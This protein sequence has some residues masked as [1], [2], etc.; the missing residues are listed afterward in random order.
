MEEKLA[1]LENVVFQVKLGTYAEKC[2]RISNLASYIAKKVGLKPASTR[3]S[4]LLCKADLVSDMVGEF[5]D[6]QG[7]MGS[8]YARHDGEA[9][10]VCVAIAEHY[11]PTQSGGVLPTSEVGSCVA[12][13]DKIDSLVG[14]FGIKQPPTGSRDP[15]AL[16]RQA[17][18]V[19]RICIEN[20]VNLCLEGVLAESARLYGKGF[21][22]TSVSAYIVERL[23]NY[24]QELGIAG[25]VV[26]AATNS[27]NMSINL[28]E[29]DDVVRTLQSF[30]DG[31]TAGSI[32]AANKRVANLLKKAGPNELIGAF[33]SSLASEEA[34]IRLGRA[35]IGLDL[36]KSKGAGEKL[37]KLA[38]LQGPVD[39][40]FDEVMVMA[41]DHKV[42]G[43]RLGLLR[44]L[45]RQFLEVADFSLLQ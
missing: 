44:E 38:V 45:R 19:V 12:L 4:G 23:A 41:E 2:H 22:S 32:I 42:R 3:R 28:L 35:L 43:N 30:R 7:T 24:Y 34:E 36:S 5:P 9:E 21:D 37:A 40:F 27:A 16:R 15:F 25:D 8:Y 39:Q 13:A 17:L 1:Q 10:E 11:R 14:I 33:D 26:E 6:L 29:I 20:R 31:P 18:G